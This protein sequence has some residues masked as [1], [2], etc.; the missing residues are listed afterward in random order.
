[1]DGGGD[2]RVVDDSAVGA[3]EVV[4]ATGVGVG[5]AVAATGVGMG[6]ATTGVGVMLVRQQWTVGSVDERPGLTDPGLADDRN[7]DSKLWEIRRPDELGKKTLC[8][9]AMARFRFEMGHDRSGIELNLLM[10]GEEDSP[11]VAAVINVGLRSQQIWNVCVVFFM[12]NGSDGPSGRSPVVGSTAMGV[13]G[14]DVVGRSTV[15]VHGSTDGG[16]VTMASWWWLRAERRAKWP[17]SV[18]LR[19][20]QGCRPSWLREGSGVP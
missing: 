11:R 6:V 1:M 4:A 9:A 8:A 18:V 2:R 10:T 7:E 13:G 15:A 20:R 16:S 17:A 5:K 19:R 14:T 3:G 12:M